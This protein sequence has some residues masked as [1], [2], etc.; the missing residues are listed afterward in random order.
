MTNTAF[1]SILT[2]LITERGVAILDSPAK[3][4][5]LLQDYAAG[6]FKR[7]IRLLMQALDAGAY[8][9]I[10]QSDDPD[11]GTQ[12]TIQ[13]LQD[14]YAIA[15][16]A[17][18]ETVM[19]LAALLKNREMTD[20]EKINQLEKLVQKE[21]NFHEQYELGLLLEKQGRFQEACT[22]FKG[23][24]KNLLEN[25]GT[26]RNIPSDSGK[27]TKITI[28]PATF[29]PQHIAVN[30]PNVCIGCQ[31]G[32]NMEGRCHLFNEPIYEAAQDRYCSHKSHL[33]K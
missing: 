20:E 8:K 25:T 7:E 13:K 11:I 21:G 5:G 16:K 22:W 17:A 2:K 10:F 3:C 19:A 6:G 4:N 15:K 30:I 32:N 31:Y 12:K 1:E 29:M 27:T 24:S 14:E 18:E 26:A 9:E 28:E 23:I 33:Y